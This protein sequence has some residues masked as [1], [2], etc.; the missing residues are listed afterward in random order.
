MTSKIFDTSAWDPIG[1]FV[2]NDQVRLDASY[3]GLNL[4]WSPNINN[5]GVQIDPNT[6]QFDD[7][8]LDLSSYKQDFSELD[9]MRL[10]L[11][12]TGINDTVVLSNLAETPKFNTIWRFSPGNDIVETDESAG[13]IINFD[14]WISNFVE[15]EPNYISGVSYNVQWTTDHYAIDIFSNENKIG[16]TNVYGP[17]HDLDISSDTT[18][19]LSD[20]GEDVEY[21]SGKANVTMGAG[22]DV[23]QL[24]FEQESTSADQLIIKGFS[25]TDLIEVSYDLSSEN[26][27]DILTKY[28]LSEI[29]K[30]RHDNLKSETYIDFQTPFGLIENYLVF[31]SLVYLSSLYTTDNNEFEIRLSDSEED[32]NLITPDFLGTN[33]SAILDNWLSVHGESLAQAS[34]GTGTLSMMQTVHG[35]VALLSDESILAVGDVDVDDVNSSGEV[36]WDIWFNSL[37]SGVGGWNRET[38]TQDV[39]SLTENGVQFTLDKHKDNTEFN[40]LLLR[41][42][43]PEDVDLTGTVAENFDFPGVAYIQSEIWYNDFDGDGEYSTYDRAK[44]IPSDDT[45]ESDWDNKV[46]VEDRN[47]QLIMKD[48]DYNDI[49]ISW[50]SNELMGDNTIIGTDGDDFASTTEVFDFSALAITTTITDRFGNAMTS[51]EAQAY[52]DSVNEITATSTTG[53]VTVFETAS[54]SDLLID[55]AMAI[56]TA[57]DKAIGAFDALQALRLAVGLDKSDG[58]SEWHDYIAADIN[59]DGRV[60]ADDALNILKFAV[61]LTDGPSADWV[62]VD[63]DADYSAIDRKNTDYDEGILISDVMTD[64]S[65]NMTGIL[66]GDV[67]GSY[68]VGS[69]TD[70]NDAPTVAN[71]ISDQTIAE[72]SA[73]SFQFA[74]DV[75]SDVDAGDSLTYAATLA[76]GSTLPSWLSFDASSRTFSGTPSN[77]DV[78]AID[79][80]VTATDGSSAPATD[81]FTLTVTNTNDAPTVANAI[82][83]Q[84]IAEDSAL[85]FQFASDVFSDVDAGDS[86]TYAATLADGSTLPSWLSF[87]ASSRTFSGTPSNGDVGAIDV[88]VTATDGSSAPATDTF[89]L[90]VTNT[91]D[92]P[93]VAN[94]I[95]DQTI[96]EDSALSFQFAS[97]VFSDVDAGDS[98][99]YTATLADGNTL[100]SWLSFDASSRTF[101]GTPSNGMLVPLMSK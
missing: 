56:D 84:T 77:G 76:D 83:D 40:E 43:P 95:S 33:T 49:G 94:A 4:N 16:I 24:T 29:V 82:S 21:I 35:A 87:D 101:S 13:L 52:E 68:N 19:T 93:T 48:A 31:D 74:S 39:L 45:G 70:A 60:G 46:S 75:F 66:V 100:P 55:A 51:A 69:V 23:I 92:A 1:S 32:S 28:Q 63:G 85:S 5:Y 37:G 50:V 61:G 30:L 80:K 12:G 18:L 97:D 86:L 25:T 22:T 78:G 17:V 3:G 72:D 27:E 9:M 42:A 98:L 54:G 44:F 6:I 81:T 14:N 2:L 11:E 41:F 91:N 99:T 47:G 96:A 67:D 89:T 15:D 20:E 26:A 65:I 88:K 59:K 7:V 36:Y 73:L 90:T 10:Y 62:F 58:T 38:G 8:V 53:N 64:L 57:S 79:V 71:A 34:D